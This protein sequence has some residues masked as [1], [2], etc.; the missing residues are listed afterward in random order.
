M[1]NWCVVDTAGVVQEVFPPDRAG[2]QLAV[3]FAMKEGGELEIVFLD[4][5]VKGGVV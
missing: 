3:K 5:P 2:W 1:S 4:R